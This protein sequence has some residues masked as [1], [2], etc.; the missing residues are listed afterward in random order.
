MTKVQIEYTVVIIRTDLCPEIYEKIKPTFDIA[1][2]AYSTEMALLTGEYELYYHIDKED[3]PGT[4]YCLAVDKNNTVIGFILL[5]TDARTKTLWT[6]HVY[7]RPEVRQKGVYKLMIE[8]VKKFARDCRFNRMFSIVH[9][10]NWTS[11]QAH[12]KAGFKKCWV[13]YEIPME[14][15]NEQQ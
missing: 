8:R 9:R 10:K 1:K 6:S 2:G 5:E 12:K 4:M 14:N 11:Q 15:E 13:G 3:A 7:V